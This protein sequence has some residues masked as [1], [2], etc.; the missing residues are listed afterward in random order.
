[1]AFVSGVSVA[2]SRPSTS[3]AGCRLAR[4]PARASRGPTMSMSSS[5]PFL[6]KPPKLD[7]S[8]P[9][10]VGFDPLGFSNMF[11]LNFLRES[12]VKHGRV[13]MLAIVGW[14][15]PEVVYHLPAAQYSAVN[16]LEAPGMVGFAS[17][18]QI[19]LFIAVV[20]AATWEKCYSGNAGGDYGFDVRWRPVFLVA[21]CFVVSNVLV[22]ATGLMRSNL[23]P[24]SS[25]CNCSVR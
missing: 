5:V 24:S 18:A 7:G 10:D 15:F 16:P 4:A 11:D 2:L 17:Y 20:E 21:V 3:F 23:L 22:N 14:F 1:M 12:E 13:C 25:V 19:L 9:G 6:E 8:L